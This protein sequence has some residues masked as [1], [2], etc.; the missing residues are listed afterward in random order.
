MRRSPA[1][2]LATTALAGAGL[3]APAHAGSWNAS[4]AA[5]RAGAAF[6]PAVA[7]DARGRLA[8]GW[9]RE[10]RGGRRAELRTGSLRGFLRGDA[11][12]VDHTSS[13]M[14][15]VTLG[16]APDGVLGVVWRRLLSRAQRLRGATV[17]T[18]GSTSG[19]FELT[20]DGPE[21]A[22]DPQFVAGA[23]GTLRAVWARRTASQSALVTGTSFGPATALPSPG[24]GAAPAVAVDRDGTTVVAWTTGGRM[25]TAMAPAGGAFGPAV[26]LPS[27]GYA[28]DPHIALTADGDVVTAWLASAGAG[29]AIVAAARPPGGAFGTPYEIAP[30]GEHAFAP[31]LAATS[32]G[33]VLVA[34]VASPQTRGYGGASGPVRLQRLGGDERPVGPRVPMSPSG[35]RAFSPSIAHDGTGSAF[36]GWTDAHAGRRAVQVRRVAPGGIVGAVRDLG[37]G[38]L[39]GSASP[40]LAG[41]GGRGVAV[42]VRGDRV[43]YSVYR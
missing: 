26:T 3:P 25:L 20:P 29:N 23:D 36:V 32:A 42:W 10:L 40:E 9:V 35:V 27:P 17:S 37:P 16:Y 7:A 14:D 24:N 15:A 28:R 1:L 13:N 22:Y 8:V 38:D 5:T 33:E 41:A 34:Y 21:S 39:R 31:R 2:L 11:N 43:R 4:R 12:V 30:A 19:P 18:G 6:Q